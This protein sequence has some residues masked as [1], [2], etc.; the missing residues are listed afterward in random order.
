MLVRSLCESTSVSR[1]VRR[2][3][4]T[5]SSS[6]TPHAH[7]CSSRSELSC[8]MA[9]MATERLSRSLLP[10]WCSLRICRWGAP[11]LARPSMNVRRSGLCGVASP[12]PLSFGDRRGSSVMSCS[13]WERDRQ[14]WRPRLLDRREEAVEEGVD[15]SS[16]DDKEVMAVVAVAR[17]NPV[18][19]GTR[20]IESLLRLLPLKESRVGSSWT[21][22]E[23]DRGGTC[24]D[25]GDMNEDVGDVMAE[26]ES[27]F[28]SVR[29]GLTKRDASELE[30]RPSCCGS[31]GASVSSS[32][33]VQPV[34]SLTRRGSW[35]MTS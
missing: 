32:S 1:S 17:R 7:K 31:G 23:S 9:A 18:L 27:S 12:G 19:P 13:W 26:N 11:G 8:E 34:T 5:A 22:E 30:R 10:W 24:T 20:W 6:V 29:G 25:D 4:W 3:R 16:L 33:M 14:P 28:E 35:R 21:E 15:N 2:A